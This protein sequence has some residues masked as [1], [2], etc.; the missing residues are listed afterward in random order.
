M[1][2]SPG[3]LKLAE[4]A[5]A[6]VR[7]ISIAHVKAKLDAG[8]DNEWQNGHLPKARHLGRGVIERDIEKACPDAGR[9]IVL[10]CGGGYRSALAAESLGKLGYTNVHSMAGGFRGW[11]EAK[12]PT[13]T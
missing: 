8:E 5:R 3:F 12:L 9:E 11:T 1:D 6:N 13:E 4:A 7:E 2:H 10:Y